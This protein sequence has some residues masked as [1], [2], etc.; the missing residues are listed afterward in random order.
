MSLSIKPVFSDNELTPLAWFS[1]PV[2]MVN[3]ILARRTVL[4]VLLVLGITVAQWILFVFENANSISVAPVPT[5]CPVTACVECQECVNNCSLCP[6]EQKITSAIVDDAFYSQEMA[7]RE[8]IYQDKMTSM[9]AWVNS[10]Q[11]PVSPTR[12]HIW[13]YFE[14]H[15]WCPLGRPRELV[16]QFGDGVK[17][18]CGPR[19][20]PDNCTI[21]SYGSNND[22]QF[23]DA[24]LDTSTCSVWTYD[25]TSSP[26][27]SSHSGRIHFERVGLGLTTAS[28]IRYNTRTIQDQMQLNGHEC[29]DVLKIDIEGL[30]WEL[31]T[32]WHRTS[33]PCFRQLQVEMHLDFNGDRRHTY[34]KL[35]EWFHILETH[36]YRLFSKEHNVYSS[37]NTC[38][39]EWAFI[40]YTP[41]LGYY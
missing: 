2:V 1:P 31:V 6:S 14:P 24:L 18:V 21:Y 27:Q 34:P 25:P 7:M 17:W 3:T 22:F 28:H 41:E 15:W 16:G 23:E 29:I 38:C 4:I 39:V 9:W 8:E 26:P 37:P 32:E 40:R 20:L 10:K 35:V 5:P 30:E 12:P 19:N 11:L 36:N 33:W 13:F